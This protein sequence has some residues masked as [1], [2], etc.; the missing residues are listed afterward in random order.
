MIS[1]FL[2]FTAGL[3]LGVIVG[4]VGTLIL[5]YAIGKALEE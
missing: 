3:I 1:E 4:V 5:A 2:F